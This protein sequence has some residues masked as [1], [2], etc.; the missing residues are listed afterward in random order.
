MSKVNNLITI[1]KSPGQ[2]CAKIIIYPACVAKSRCREDKCFFFLLI[3]KAKSFVSKSALGLEY[4]EHGLYDKRMHLAWAIKNESKTLDFPKSKCLLP[5]DFTAKSFDCNKKNGPKR[6]NF[7]NVLIHSQCNL[8]T[9][10]I[11]QNTKFNENLVFYFCCGEDISVAEKTATK[12]KLFLVA[13]FRGLALRDKKKTLSLSSKLLHCGWAISIRPSWTLCPVFSCHLVL[14]DPR[15]TL[16]KTEFFTASPFV[17][18]AT[19]P[20][21]IF[22]KFRVCSKGIT[23]YFFFFDH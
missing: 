12:A 21:Q 1:I 11:Q 3:W 13:R 2:I 18:S 14:S 15:F 6:L 9:L 20:H 8:S 22:A 4:Y 23:E 17:F 5:N 16:N 7:S 10:N 19:G